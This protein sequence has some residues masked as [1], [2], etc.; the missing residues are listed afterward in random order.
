MSAL[1]GLPRAEPLDVVAL[2]D[3][4][5]NGVDH[6]MFSLSGRYLFDWQ[7][8]A[9]VDPASPCFGRSEDLFAISHL[10][11]LTAVLRARRSAV[12]SGVLLEGTAT[13]RHFARWFLEWSSPAAPAGWH[14]IAPPS[15]VPVLDDRFTTWSP[16]GP[17]D[18]FVRLT[19]ED[20]A[21]HRRTKVRRVSSSETPVLTDLHV[22]P[23]LFP[24]NGDG[25]LDTTALHYTVAV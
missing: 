8:P 15:D 18:F 12:V 1:A 10:G 19:V 20:L 23:T 24:P 21:G 3:T 16:P 5:A 25:V 9:V 14:P 17:G 7:R 22:E 4:S 13:D 2:L 6:S 11:N